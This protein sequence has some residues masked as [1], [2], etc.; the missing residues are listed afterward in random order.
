M[1][2]IKICGT[3]NLEDAQM[4]VE[5]G[6]DALGFIFAESPR[7]INSRTAAKIIADLPERVEKVGVF[8]NQPIDDV[9]RTSRES[10]LTAIQLHGDEL[11]D[12]VAEVVEKTGLK[13]L[14][15]V[16]EN[17]PPTM[18]HS[19]HIHALLFD[20]ADGE[21]TGGTGISWDWKEGSA[22]FEALGKAGIRS[23]VAGGLN[24]ENVGEAIR[25]L[26][27][28]GVDVVTGVEREPGKKDPKKVKAF[29]EAVRR[30][31]AR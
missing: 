23:V 14:L 5:A 3:T 10:A 30:A 11:G 27:P 24:P 7:K 19:G 15:R 26:H 20:Y 28:W 4:C 25:I 13:V 29:I 21:R 18:V 16:R 31:D 12:Y 2:W 8:V 1:T 9:A 22:A 6:A 17:P